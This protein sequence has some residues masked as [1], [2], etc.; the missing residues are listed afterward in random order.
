[1]QRTVVLLFL[2]LI[3]IPILTSCSASLE[4]STAE[5]VAS[6]EHA[7]AAIDA[8][9]LVIDV[10]RPHEFAAGHVDGAVNMPHDQIAERISEISGDRDQPVVV[11]CRSG[12]RAGLAKEVL[13]SN[14][15]TDILNAGGY[16]DL[17]D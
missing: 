2:L 1:M 4:S 9:A 6:V 11:Y 12:R 17:K 8:G 3:G 5:S 7:R 14:G 13:R 15:F 10:R 16:S